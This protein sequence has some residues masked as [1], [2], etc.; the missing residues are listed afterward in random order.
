MTV[1]NE[2]KDLD[3]GIGVFWVGGGVVVVEGRGGR[4]GR[5]GRGWN[6]MGW[7]GIGVGWMGW[8][9]MG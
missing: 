9:R 4:M 8:D 5:I 2:R 7:D 6:G 1:A 3:E